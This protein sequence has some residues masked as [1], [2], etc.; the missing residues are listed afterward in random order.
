MILQ[1]VF[2]LIM[3]SSLS[4]NF[5]QYYHS[6]L[7]GYIGLRVLTAIQYLVVVKL[8]KGYEKSCLVFRNTFLDWDY[9]LIYVYLFESWIRYVVL[10]AGILFDIIVPFWGRKYLVKAPIN[11][12]HLLE[13][14]ALLTL[15][16]L[17]NLS[18]VLLL[19][20]SHKRRLAFDLIF[21]RFIYSHYF[22]VVAI[23]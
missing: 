8:E 20:Y 3:I 17:G 12:A 2:V 16:L 1:M 22:H 5:D 11:T 4:V 7:I 18:S 21:N 6:F 9:H 15:I 10:Y 13:R 19:Y 14:F 23:F